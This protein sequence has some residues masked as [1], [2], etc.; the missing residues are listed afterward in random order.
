MLP[1]KECM[2]RNF[3][4]RGIAHGIRVKVFGVP[5]RVTL[6]K[7]AHLF[8]IMAIFTADLPTVFIHLRRNQLNAKSV[9][10]GL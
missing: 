9:T 6:I 2:I 10:Y 7:S 8:V 1:D 4:H 3:R 5:I